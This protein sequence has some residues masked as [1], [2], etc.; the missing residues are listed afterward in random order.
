MCGGAASATA[1]GI[2]EAWKLARLTRRKQPSPR[3]G[4]VRDERGATA[5]ELA[6]IGIPLIGVL[7]A[8]L[9]TAI[10]FFYDQA[11]QTVTNTAARQILTGSV[12]TQGLAPGGQGTTG[13]HGVV[14]TAASGI[15]PCA[16]LM[17]DVQSAT[18]F[19]TLNTAPITPTYDSNGV[20]NNMNFSPGAQNAAVIVRVMYDWPVFGGPLGL[21]LANQS[22][23]TRLMVGT[24]VFKTEPY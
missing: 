1:A 17:V 20:V 22:N 21:G 6:L 10:I 24:A 13:F 23:G 7:V 19:S 4:F 16:G 14:C 11:I 12:Q 15:F 9:Q 5:V 8:A 3:G 18:S 2:H